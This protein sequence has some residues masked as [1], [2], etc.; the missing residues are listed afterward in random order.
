MNLPATKSV[1]SGAAV[2]LNAEATGADSAEWYNNGELIFTDT[3]GAGDTTTQYGYTAS[4][5]DGTDEYHVVFRNSTGATAESVHCV[6]TVTAA[7]GL[8]VEAEA[9]PKRERKAK[10]EMAT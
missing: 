3:M 10:A 4:M 7:V 1:V 5:T 2:T 8:A 6:V 9:A